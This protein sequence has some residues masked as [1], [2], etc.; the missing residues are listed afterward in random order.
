[1]PGHIREEKTFTFVFRIIVTGFIFTM[2]QRD[3]RTDISGHGGRLSTENR[4][5]RFGF[6][7]SHKKK[8]SKNF[9]ASFY[10]NT[11]LF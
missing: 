5:D 1:M 7:C 8:H 11:A 4:G 3:A 10:L 9:V 6:S 2:D